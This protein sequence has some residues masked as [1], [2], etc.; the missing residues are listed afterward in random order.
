MNGSLSVNEINMTASPEGVVIAVK[1]KP[2]AKRDAISGIHA[3]ALKVDV[4]APPDKF[5]ANA[6]VISLIAK[7]FNVPRA[8]VELIS[9]AKSRQKRILLG[10]LTEDDVISTLSGKGII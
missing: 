1:V 7:F 4:T 2:K 3:G 5:K 8:K 9:G 10:G 6:A